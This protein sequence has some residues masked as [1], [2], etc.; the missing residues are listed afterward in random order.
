MTLTSNSGNSENKGKISHQKT[1]QLLNQ[2]LNYLTEFENHYGK[3]FN[4]S[5]LARLLGLSNGEIDEII[6]LL[7]NFQEV[8]ESVFKNYQLKKIRTGNQLYLIAN[9]KEIDA[10]EKF[11]IPEIVNISNSH[12]KLFNDIIYVFKFVKRG[13]GFDV[14]QNG[15]E[16][17]VNLKQLK[18]DHPYLFES[19]GNGIIYPSEMGLKLGELIISYNKSNKE[20]KQLTVNNCTF[21]VEKNG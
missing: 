17:L 2:I 21:I 8:F 11:E 20:I 19:K 4:V 18:A 15:S 9:K 6:S 14:I 12:L 5:K 3:K 1:I 16:L 13:K 10:L 7:L